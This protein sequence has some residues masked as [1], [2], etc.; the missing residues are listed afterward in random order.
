[1][2]IGLWVLAWLFSRHQ[3]SVPIG[4]KLIWLWK[5]LPWIRGLALMLL[6]AAPWYALAEW[7]TP[8]FLN[9][10]LIG[11]HWNRFTQPGWSG[12]L[13]GTAHVEPRGT[14]WFFALAAC[15]PWSLLLPFASWP[16]RSRN[17]TAQEAASQDPYPL[18]AGS[19]HWYLWAWALAPCI[20]FTISRNTLWTYVLPGL[21]AAAALAAL[22]LA[23]NARPR[24]VHALVGGG[25]LATSIV[26]LVATLALPAMHNSAQGVAA[27]YEIRRARTEPIVFIGTD[28]YSAA[29]YTRGQAHIV[30]ARLWQD[31]PS[32]PQALEQVRPS[33]GNVGSYFLALRAPQWKRWAA[34]LGPLTQDE[35]HHGPYRLLRVKP[36]H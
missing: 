9:Y 1:L 6:I 2:P 11:E 4:R 23:R 17:T 19:L 36:A 30:A 8:G 28:Q 27:A 24:R 18:G 32:A 7:R 34:E 35:G 26:F 10:F 15:L 21:P 5:R 25:L 31:A 16:G 20:F 14:I 33:Q 13:Y 12:D 29:F 3:G 22:W